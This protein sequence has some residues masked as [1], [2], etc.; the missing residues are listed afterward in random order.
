MI[1]NMP[2]LSVS[3]VLL[4]IRA[5]PSW[6]LHDLPPTRDEAFSPHLYFTAMRLW[7]HLRQEGYTML[8]SRRARYLYLLAHRADKLGIPGDLVDCGVWNGGSTVLLSQGAPLRRVWAF[9]SF[10]GLPEPGERDGGRS[11]GWAGSCLGS[12]QMVEAAF[13]T[14]GRRQQLRIVEGWFGETF[15]EVAPQITTV[16]LL[17]ADGDWYESVLLT[18]ETFGPKLAPG[19]FTIVDDYGHWEGARQAAD[20]FRGKHNISSPLR[21]IDGNAV[22]WSQI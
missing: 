19:G 7:Y 13:R 17:H 16:A 14:F 4:R 18:L 11:I 15:P 1:D 5:R 3:D 2:R 9:D 12:V 6:L 10:R 21:Q 20:D 8:G 22:F